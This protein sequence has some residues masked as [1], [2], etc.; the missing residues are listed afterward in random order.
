MTLFFRSHP[1]S[2]ELSYGN[3][4]CYECG[5][6]VYNS[7]LEALSEAAYDK[8]VGFLKDEA[9]VSRRNYRHWQWPVNEA[10]LCFPQTPFYI[11]LLSIAAKHH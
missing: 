6:Y 2:V 5:D 1:C 8:Y 9:P 4:F 7:D 11:K 3:V 10:Y